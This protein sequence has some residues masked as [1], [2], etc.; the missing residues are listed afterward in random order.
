MSLVELLVGVVVGLFIVAGAV[1]LFVGNLSS[2]RKLLLE[3]RIN[4]DL[5]AT[6]DLITRDLRRAGYW[7]NAISGTIAAGASS[8]TVANQYST[9]TTTGTD[10]V[11]YTFARDT[12][13]VV[14]GNEQFGFRLAT[15]GGIGRIEMQVSNGSW[16][17]VTDPTAM[18][19]TGLVITPV[20][21]DVAVGGACAKVC[22]PPVGATYTCPN[23]PVITV[24]QYDIQLT[25]AAISD[26]AV[27]RTLQTRARVRNDRLSG[28]CPA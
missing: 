4:Q 23:P 3:A 19:V 12:N 15:T 2:S 21:T 24:R 22:P 1:T 27:V 10:Q 20:V 5:R 11:V 14:D 13:N 17:P 26:A 7:E 9:V 28:V 25:G 16:Q 18:N 6:A 8:V